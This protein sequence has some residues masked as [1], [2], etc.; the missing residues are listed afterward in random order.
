MEFIKFFNLKPLLFISALMPAA[1]IAVSLPPE[2]NKIIQQL[3]F[4][5]QGLSLIVHEINQPSPTVS[6]AAQTPRNPASVIKL[7]TTATALAKLGI[8]FQ[9]PT[10][11]YIT[12]S[13]NTDSLSG[14]LYIKGYGDPFF[15]PEFFWRFVYH[16]HLKGLRHI[17]GDVILD[18]SHF[19]VAAEDP[20]KF[21]G[22]PFRSYNVQPDALLLN[23]QSL[24]LQITPKRDTVEVQSFPRLSNLNIVNKLSLTQGRCGNWQHRITYLAKFTSNITIDLTGRFAQACNTRTLYRSVLPKI[25]FFEGTLRTLWQERGGRISGQFRYGN[26]PKN[27]T[28]LYQAKSLPLA[29]IVRR[30]NK[31]SNNVMTQQLLLTLGAELIGPPGTH[32]AGIKVITDWLTEQQL[33]TQNLVL[34]NGAGRSRNTR[35]TAQLLN[36]LLLQLYEQAYM[37]EFIASLPVIGVDGTLAKRQTHTDLTGKAHIK[38]G[39]LDFVR[40]MAGYVHSRSGKRFV[41]VLLHNHPKAHTKQGERLQ[42]T[43]L[44]WVYTQS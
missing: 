21:D 24:A 34:E 16:L 27:A 2:L 7:L 9:W 37:P 32:E 5:H 12:K 13:F 29:E 17:N 22:K 11:A 40:S 23:F 28:L 19:A 8:N 25:A 10:E 41:V 42:N 44:N 26:V 1:G 43:V 4:D 15:M 20:G 39:L 31:Y 36:D 18:R 38:T 14:N 33:D 3:G 30:I 35:I 6:L